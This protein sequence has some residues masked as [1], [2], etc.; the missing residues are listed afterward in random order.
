MCMVSKEHFITVKISLGGNSQGARGQRQRQ[1]HGGSC[2]LFAPSGAAHRGRLIAL[3]HLTQN[4]FQTWLDVKCNT[5]QKTNKTVRLLAYP[6]CLFR[7]GWETPR[8]VWVDCRLRRGR[9]RRRLASWGCMTKTSPAAAPAT[10]SSVRAHHFMFIKYSRC[11]YI[12]AI[13]V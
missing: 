9:R 2:P 8:P 3:K 1:G 11:S 6:E 5:R 4:V 10:A 13:I 12:S 7:C